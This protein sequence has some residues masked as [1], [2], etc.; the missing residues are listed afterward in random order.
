MCRKQQLQNNLLQERF[1]T[2]HRVSVLG[3]VPT[4]EIIHPNRNCLTQISTGSRL[5]SSFRC[6]LETQKE[7]I[8]LITAAQIPC[9]SPS[10]GA[11]LDL[12]RIYQCR[13]TSPVREMSGINALC[14]HVFQCYTIKGEAINYTLLQ[15]R[16]LA[17]LSTKLKIKCRV[18][19]R[20]LLPWRYAQDP[21]WKHAWKSVSHQ[22]ENHSSC[23]KSPW[24]QV[25]EAELL[26]I[27][28]LCSSLFTMEVRF[29]VDHLQK[30]EVSC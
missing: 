2:T 27:S 30:A 9:V 20:S 10:I 22:H 28:G 12:L 8:W 5:A 4:V 11:L 13:R 14:A 21:S 24:F 15:L 29:P 1:E 6:H 3:L 7:W 18:I 25:P 26:F 23:G 17:L 16:A 19:K